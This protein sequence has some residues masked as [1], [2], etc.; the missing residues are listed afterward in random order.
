MGLFG[1]ARNDKKTWA[2]VVMPETDRKLDIPVQVLEHATNSYIQ[3]H[4]RILNESIGIVLSTKNADTRKSRFDLCVMH[5]GA[6]IKVKKYADK[7]QK[8]EINKAIDSFC[9]MEDQYRHPNR[10]VAQE[11]LAQRKQKK[12]E[13]WEDVG[14]MEM[15]DIFMDD[16]SGKK[17]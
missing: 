5:Y 12:D 16:M 15:V 17:K 4:L 2:S 11:Q 8:K 3:Q 14:V 6:L 10:A 13:F 7:Q 9:A 1:N